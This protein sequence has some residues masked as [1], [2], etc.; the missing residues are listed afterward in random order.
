M[1][2]SEKLINGKWLENPD[3]TRFLQCDVNVAMI[4]GQSNLKTLKLSTIYGFNAWPDRTNIG[5]V[6]THGVIDVDADGIVVFTT[7]KKDSPDYAMIGWLYTIAPTA[8]TLAKREMLFPDSNMG[9]F[10]TIKNGVV[11]HFSFAGFW[12][13]RGVQQTE[14]SSPDDA[15]SAYSKYRLNKIGV[16]GGRD[17]AECSSLAVQFISR[18]Q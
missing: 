18:W 12:S 10:P 11:S 17:A 16:G 5:I 1:L 14:R 6:R 15:R 3:G 13:F 4:D 9:W 2:Y 7:E 8:L